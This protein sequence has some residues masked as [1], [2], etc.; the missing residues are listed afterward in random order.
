MTVLEARDLTKLYG[1]HLA[2]DRLNIAVA[3]GETLCLL[4]ANGAGKTTTLNLFLGFT[5]PTSGQAL[6]SGHDVAADPAAARAALGYVAEV[7]SLYPSLSGAENL[8]FFAQ[9]AGQ[10]PRATQRDAILDRLRFPASAIAR[11]AGD[12]SKGMRQKLG[13][14]IALMK[15]AKAIL[16]DEPLSGLDPAAANDLVAVLRE[17]AA[18]GTALLVSTHDIF[19]AK[20][21]ATRIGIMRHGRL[22]DTVDPGALSGPELESLYLTHMAERAA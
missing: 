19:R 10:A 4:G 17:T 2:L 13:L 11:P 5:A 18:G 15:G 22:V 9:L 14:A 3:A 21:V 7:V 8:A 20:D 6:V 12:Y 16:L 1:D